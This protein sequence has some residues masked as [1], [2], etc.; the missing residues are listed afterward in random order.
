[1]AGA[2]IF[3]KTLPVRPWAS[4]Q[5]A[6][7]PG[8]SPV[9]PGEWF[10]ID[11]AFAA[12]MAYR[13][14]LLAGRRDAVYALDAAARPAARELL[15]RVLGEV[16]S[17]PGYRREGEAVWRPDGVRV[18]I[19]RDEPLVT[20]ARL[21]QE[22]L[23]LMEKPEGGAE[24][25][26]TGA[27]LCFPA[28]WTLAE[29]RGRPLTAIHTPVPVYDAGLAKRVQRLLD[30][31]QPDRPIWRA[32]ALIYADPELHQPRREA[33]RRAPPE[34]DARWLRVE[35]QVLARLPETGAVAFTIH[36]FVLPFDALSAED[37]TALAGLHAATGSGPP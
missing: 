25:L 12:Q 6:R 26:L 19:D 1:M 23:V 24:H 31:I 16:L 37:R 33:D 20:A 14:R 11:D 4:P 28:S 27:A 22:D 30:G 36:T 3:Q 9:A 10:L 32:N 18:P 17:K 29:K 7:L 2:P 15:A 35:R 21:V 5:T 34:G 8:L 13:D